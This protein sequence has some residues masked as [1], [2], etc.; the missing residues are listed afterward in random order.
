MSMSLL[1]LKEDGIC[2]AQQTRYFQSFSIGVYIY[3]IT[4]LQSKTAENAK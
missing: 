4:H 2:I 3:F 1:G